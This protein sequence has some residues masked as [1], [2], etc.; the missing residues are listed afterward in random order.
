[1]GDNISTLQSI[2]EVK[3]ITID[4]LKK[5]SELIMERKEKELPK[6]FSWFS[7]LMNKFGWHRKY[8]V[9]VIDKE[10]FSPFNQFKNKGH[11]LTNQP[12]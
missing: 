9:I 1:M 3:T 7:R 6:G 10:V 11:K 8:E 5:A 4:D 2:A 12:K